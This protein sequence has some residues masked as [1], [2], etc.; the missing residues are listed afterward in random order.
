MPSGRSHAFGWKATGT[1]AK[2]HAVQGGLPRDMN[3]V[4]VRPSLACRLCAAAALAFINAAAPAWAAERRTRVRP[5]SM[6]IRADRHADAGRP[7]AWRSD[8]AAASQPGVMGQLIAGLCSALPF[9]A[10]FFRTCSTR[11]FPTNAEQKAM[12]DAISQFGILLLL[13][14]TGMETD[15]KLVRQSGRAS[16]FASLVGI[17]IPFTLRGCDLE[18]AC[19][20]ACCRTREAPDHLA[21]SR[22]GLVDRLGENRGDGDPRNEFHAPRRSARSSSLLRSSMTALVG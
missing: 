8:D 2:A 5:N 1:P 12:I 14:L 22:H 7:A 10:F 21:L 4:R 11:L 3:A 17:V 18:N 15:L 6:F 16:L 20:T 19:R 9:L 13:L